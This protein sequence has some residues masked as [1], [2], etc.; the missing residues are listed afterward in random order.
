MSENRIAICFFGLTRSLKYTIDSIRNNI[1]KPLDNNNLKYDIYVHTYDLENE[2]Q[3][4]YEY[5]L[6]NPDFYSITNQ[7]E[8]LKSILIEEVIKY[9]DSWEDNNKS[10]KNLLCQLNSLKLVTNMWKDKTY[11]CVMYF[12]PDLL[13]H[14]PISIENIKYVIKNSLLNDI[15]IPKWHA[16]YLP[17][18]GIGD[19]QGVNDRISYGTPLSMEHY[20]SRLDKVLEYCEKTKNPLHSE[21]FVKYIIKSN[22]FIEHHIYEYASRVRYNGFMVIEVLFPKIAYNNIIAHKK[23]NFLSNRFMR[24]FKNEN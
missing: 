1:F 20:G 15:F 23:G 21:C 14:Q 19:H 17:N 9:G 22:N 18:R 5:N 10:L 2:N 7:D 3:D 16:I 6:L 11:D 24:L 13:Y 4:Q 8:F 12:R